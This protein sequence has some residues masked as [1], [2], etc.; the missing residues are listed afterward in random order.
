[1]RFLQKAEPSERSGEIE[2]RHR[3]IW[4][5]LDAPAEPRN[6]FGVCAETRSEHADTVHPAECSDIAGREAER[7]IDVELRF[8]T[9]THKKLRPT[10]ENVSVGQISI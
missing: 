7:L 4:I 3:L 10:N 2:M 8:R 6:R 9:S 1:L 5:G